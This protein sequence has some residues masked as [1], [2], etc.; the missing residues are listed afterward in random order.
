MILIKSVW[1]KDKN[2]YYYNIFLEKVLFEFPKKC[3][4]IRYKCYIMIQLTYLKE[5]ILKKQVHQKE[6]DICHDWY[7][8]NKGFKF[9]ANVCNRCHDLLM[10]MNLSDIAKLNIKFTD[11]HC[12]ISGISKSEGIN[13]M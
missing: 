9:K 6:C 5:L 1:N 8:L 7:F 10:S 13:L 3:L 11:Y 12:I 4:C 2:S